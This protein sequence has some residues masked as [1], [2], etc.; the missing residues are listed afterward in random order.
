MPLE[1]LSKVFEPFFSTK[2]I[3]KGTGLGLSQVYGF[4]RQ[5]G[6][7]VTIANRP[8]GGAVV[9]LYLPRAEAAVGEQEQETATA[10]GAVSNERILLVEDN[11]DVREVAIMLL[12]QLGYR[13]LPVENGAAALAVLE[14]GEVFDLVFSDI[15][16]PGE[17]NGLDLARHIRKP[18]PVAAHFADHRLC[19]GG[20]KRRQR[21]ADPAQ[22][23]P[24]QHLG[25]GPARR[26]RGR[27]TNDGT[28]LT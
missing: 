1:F 18:T 13:V 25:P 10:E 17:P 23:L 8:E 27:R 16:M 7:T 3:D 5:S 6:G 2:Q 19:P 26:A 21:G 12:D 28:A 15:V 4:T 24:P 20:D 11:E 14:K 9:T 22:A